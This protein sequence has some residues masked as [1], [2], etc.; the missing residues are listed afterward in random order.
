MKEQVKD[1]AGVVID[2]TNFRHYF[3]DVRQHRP[4][5]GQIM[6]KFSA[7]AVFGDGPEKRDLINVLK[8]GKGEAAAQ[9]MRK[10]HCAREPDCYRVCREMCDDLLGGMSVEEVAKKEYEFV[11]E[12]FYYTKREYVPKHDP[13]WETIDLLKYDEKTKMFKA[14]IE[15]PELPKK[16][17]A[18]DK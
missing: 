12:A 8:R 18:E 13:H 1:E 4:Q 9:V 2:H 10:I 7:V 5:P 16:E 15:L 3:F 14:V 6:A 17:E 11:L